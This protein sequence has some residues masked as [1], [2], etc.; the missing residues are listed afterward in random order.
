MMRISSLALS[1][2]TAAVSCHIPASAADPPQ[3]AYL[4]FPIR[5][6]LQKNC[7]FKPSVCYY[8]LVHGDSLLDADGKLDPSRLNFDDLSQDIGYFPTVQ[9]GDTIGAVLIFAKQP[10]R[11]AARLLNLA[12]L[13]WAIASGYERHVL[14]TDIGDREWKA[15]VKLTKDVRGLYKEEN[16]ENAVGDDTVR[17]YPVRTALSRLHAA[18]ADCVVWFPKAYDKDATGTLDDQTTTKVKNLIASLKIK[19]FKRVEFGILLKPDA[20]GKAVK[21]FTDKTAG[22]LAKILGAEQYSVRHSHV[23]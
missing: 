1:L 18:N 14:A 12:V 11:A 8:L 7:L 22:E 19:D 23:E 17:V 21:R 3:K 4:L 13:G 15:A 10:P 5:T 6:E 9:K 16:D 2:I 20:D